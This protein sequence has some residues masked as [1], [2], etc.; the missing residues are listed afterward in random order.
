LALGKTSSFRFA[1]RRHQTDTL[2][3]VKGR[4]K[5]STELGGVRSGSCAAGCEKNNF[6]S[7]LL[8]NSLGKKN[9]AC[10]WKPS[11]SRRKLYVVGIIS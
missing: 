2:A 8:K 3:A 4:A 6:P 11:G 5:R 9:L 10:S 1:A 7:E